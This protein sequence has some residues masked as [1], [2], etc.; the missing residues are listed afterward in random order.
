MADFARAMRSPKGNPESHFYLGRYYQDRGNHREAVIEFEKTLEIDPENVSALNAL[1]VSYDYLKEYQLAMKCYETVL[2][3]DPDSANVYYNNMGQSYF[4]RGQYK[5]AI[6][7]FR[8][9]AAYDEDY[10]AARVHNNLGRAYA[11]AGHYDLALAEFDKADGTVSAETVL[12]RVMLDA[13]RRNLTEGIAQAGAGVNA[14]SSRISKFLQE[15]S[16]RTEVRQEVAVAAVAE[17]QKQS[18]SLT[19]NPIICVE[20]SNGNGVESVTLNT[21]DNLIRKGYRVVRITKGLNVVHTYIYYEKGHL[22]E[23]KALARHLP[24]VVKFKEVPQLESQIKI[25]VLLG[26]DMIRYMKNPAIDTNTLN[27][28]IGA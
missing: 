3:L 2:K 16:V 24:V 7:A 14:F 17:P 28:W 4:Q 21:T 19:E 18:A 13:E 25:R 9:A 6:E 20:V 12:D 10:P 27:D 15:R 22:E 8:K 11:M 1:G 23:A 5:A 26:H